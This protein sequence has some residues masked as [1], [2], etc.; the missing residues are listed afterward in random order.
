MTL[1]VT[2]R[3]MDEVVALGRSIRQY[4]EEADIETAGQL[5]AERH[6]QLRDLFDDPGVEADEDS[7]AQWMRDI[8][9]EDQSL[10]QALAELR[11]RMELE[12]GD[13]RRSLRNARAYAAVAENPGR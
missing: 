4:V 3:R 10:M 5:A 6:Q 9:R 11:S 1:S 8:L 7:L 12:L 13:S 2:S